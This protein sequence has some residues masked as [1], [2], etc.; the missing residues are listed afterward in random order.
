MKRF[1][2]LA[3]GLRACAH[4]L[5]YRYEDTASETVWFGKLLAQT[6]GSK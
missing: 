4:G 3:L 5:L 1:K 6:I 2:E